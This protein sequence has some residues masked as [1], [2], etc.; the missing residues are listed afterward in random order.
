MTDSGATRGRQGAVEDLNESILSFNRV[1]LRNCRN[2]AMRH[3]FPHETHDCFLELLYQTRTNGVS[4][5]ELI[6]SP[7]DF[8][9]SGVLLKK[10]AWLC[11]DDDGLF[12]ESV[13]Y[14][15]V[16]ETTEDVRRRGDGMLVSV[17]SGMESE[18]EDDMDS[19]YDSDAED[20]MDTDDESTCTDDPTEDRSGSEDTL[21]PDRDSTMEIQPVNFN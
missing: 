14:D 11:V 18:S 20:I 7:E 16:V 15:L 10:I 6:T 19:A 1:Y 9:G 4:L 8:D 2:T 17:P 12:D 3:P 13:S 21:T 5:D